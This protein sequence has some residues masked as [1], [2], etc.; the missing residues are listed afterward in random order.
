MKWLTFNGVLMP[1]SWY[2][3]AINLT[4]ENVRGQGTKYISW[5]RKMWWKGQKSTLRSSWPIKNSP[6][7][8]HEFSIPLNCLEFVHHEKSVYVSWPFPEHHENQEIVVQGVLWQDKQNMAGPPFL[9]V[10]WESS[11]K[12]SWCSR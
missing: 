4:H 8:T 2:H 9:P 11:K 6:L 5:A 10:V 3:L 7:M 1:F 12:A